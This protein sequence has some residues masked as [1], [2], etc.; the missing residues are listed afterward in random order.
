MSGRP[1]SPRAVERGSGTVLALATVAVLAAVTA[2]VVLVCGAWVA[3]QRAGIAADAAA[4][5][6]ADVAVG[7]A[8]GDPCTQA[9]LVARANGA[10]LAECAVAGVVVTVTAVVPYAGWRAEAPARAGPPGT[11]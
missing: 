4:L 10:P 11:P 3:R 2:A 5:A 9:R 8:A 6:G 7:R 1:H